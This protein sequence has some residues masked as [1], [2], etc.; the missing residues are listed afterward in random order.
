MRQFSFCMGS[1]VELTACLE[2]FQRVCPRAYKSILCTIF[3][4]C[5]DSGQLERIAAQVEKYVPGV[6]VAGLTGGGGIWQ[7]KRC[8]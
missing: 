2:E 5:Q 3:T 4:D 1:P 7:G 6:V 8:E